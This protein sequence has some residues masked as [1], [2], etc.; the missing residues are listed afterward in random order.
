[1]AVMLSWRD[2][3]QLGIDFLDDEHQEMVRLI[4][5]LACC[6]RAPDGSTYSHDENSVS[7]KDN[8][9]PLI[10]R[11]NALI[12]HLRKHF[13]REEEFLKSIGYPDYF[14]HKREHSVEMA[15]FIHMRREIESRELMR[16]DESTLQE[17]KDWF[18][19]HVIAEERRI[20]DYYFKEFKSV[21]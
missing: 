10:Q 4:N 2:S 19:N 3:W 15:E 12:D 1:M 18:F 9:A 8:P 20:A 11:L 13:K 16:L 14:S 6:G 5:R 7:E 21:G 17:I